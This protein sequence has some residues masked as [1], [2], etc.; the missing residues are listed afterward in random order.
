VIHDDGVHL[1]IEAFEC[2]HRYTVEY[3]NLIPLY[4]MFTKNPLCQV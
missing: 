4:S 3:G 2:M 1:A